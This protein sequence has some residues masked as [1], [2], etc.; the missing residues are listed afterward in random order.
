MDCDRRK[1][2]AERRYSFTTGLPLAFAQQR[3]IAGQH[4]TRSTAGIPAI[5]REKNRK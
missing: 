3:R 4:E 5:R 1:L 2:K